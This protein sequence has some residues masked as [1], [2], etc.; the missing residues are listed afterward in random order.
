VNDLF[1]LKTNSEEH[2]QVFMTIKGKLIREV[3]N[4]TDEDLKEVLY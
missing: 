1:K 2:Q 3:E 4:R